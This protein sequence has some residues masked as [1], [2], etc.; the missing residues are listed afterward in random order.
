[1]T[2]V[3]WLARVI[4]GAWRNEL[5]SRSPSLPWDKLGREA[6]LMWIRVAAEVGAQVNIQ[7]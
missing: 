7:P 1:V 6:Q 3:E 4:Y 2:S 5:P